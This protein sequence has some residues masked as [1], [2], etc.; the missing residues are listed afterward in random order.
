MLNVL[1]SGCSRTADGVEGDD[2][3]WPLARTLPGV[4]RV[5]RTI[6]LHPL[7][8]ATPEQAAQGKTATSRGSSRGEPV[9][10]AGSLV[11]R[12]VAPGMY[13]TDASVPR[14]ARFA[15]I[16]TTWLAYLPYLPQGAKALAAVRA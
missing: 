5:Q 7:L 16:N 11:S 1:A 13:D 6:A 2:M 10:G 14:Y 9:A 3:R 15:A 8:C 12:A 4:L